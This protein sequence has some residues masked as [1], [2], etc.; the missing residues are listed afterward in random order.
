MVSKKQKVR[1]VILVLLL[2]IA[3]VGGVFAI[4][5]Y[6][7]GVTFPWQVTAGTETK[8][9]VAEEPQDEKLTVTVVEP[10][11]KEETKKEAVTEEKPK[12]V[13]KV[14]ETTEDTPVEEAPVEETTA[15]TVDNKL[16]YY[17]QL[18]VEDGVLVD[19][20]GEAVQLTGVS[21]H[22]LSWYPEYVTADSIKALRDN[23][24]INVIRLAMYTSDYNGYCVAGEEIQSVL[25]DNIDEAVTAATENDMYVIIDW[26][27]LN[28]GNPNEYKSQAIQF[29]GE[30]VR[31]YED[32]ENVIYEI[33]NEPNGDTTWEDIK[34]YANEVIPVIRNVDE[35]ALILVGTPSYSSDLDSVLEAPLDFDNIMYTYHFY[36]GT[37]K[38]SARNSLTNALDAGLPVF[39][40]EYG[41]VSADGDGTVDTKEAEKWIDILKEYNLSS[42]IWNL[43][44]KAE[45]SA[46][47]SADC[48]KTAD[49]EYEELSEQG[50][51]F[52]DLLQN[53]KSNT[54]NKR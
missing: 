50:Q 42:C 14:E 47:I 49:F 28:D 17:G 21:S 41:L 36:A 11:A 25:K 26:H 54:E 53:N 5:Y 35:D 12:D 37:H 15:A 13:K 33:C 23:W 38:S 24:G 3:I 45:G 43:S 30:I 40:S 6:K 51:Y 27:I 52:F 19:A 2:A 16:D 46:L 39:I 9:E 31:K 48:D 44:N 32:N 8:E 34:K 22:G 7:G 29:F 10:E 18:H 20:E 1:T 4:S